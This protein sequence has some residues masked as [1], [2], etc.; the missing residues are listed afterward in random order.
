MAEE[1]RPGVLE[2]L[3][4]R[5]LEKA[6]APFDPTLID[7]TGLSDV[8]A[9]DRVALHLARQIRRSMNAL[10]EKARAGAAAAVVRAVLASLRETSRD[11]DLDDEELVE[12]ARLLRAIRTWLPDGTASAERSPLI[13]LLDTTLLTN[14]PGEP[15][16]G[17]QIDVEIESAN[18]IDLVMAFIR[19]SGINPIKDALRRH[20]ERGGRLRIITT[21]Y[22]GS[23]Q[24]SALDV[25]AA[26]GAE[27]RISY[28]LSTT[29]LHAKAWIFNRQA[30]FST[31]YIGS[32]NLTHSAQVAG[33]EWNVRVSG[34]RNPD[35]LEKMQAV[36]SAY[37]E[38]QDFVP[39]D[40]E[41]FDRAAVRAGQ[42]GPAIVISPIGVGPRPFQARLLEQLEMERAKGRHRN[43]LV[44]AT[45][46]GKTVMAALDYEQLSRTLPRARLLFIAHRKEILDQSQA[47]FCQVLQDATFG[48]KWAGGQRP[49]AF[50]HVFASIQSL[51]RA[52]LEH[53]GP[54][55]F[56]VVIVDEFHHAEA[57]TY[58]RILRHLQPRELLGL[59]A[60]PERADG[61]DILHWFG[62]RIAA[63]LR[64]W[65]A[66]E[67]QYLA[68]FS[69]FGIS[70]GLSL[71][72][73][74]WRRGVGYDVQA[75]TN[76]YT[77][78][79][80]WAGRVLKEFSSRVDDLSRVRA[81]GF[82]VSVDHAR[83]MADYFTKHGVL[84]ASVSG[85]TSRDEREQALR[86][87]ANGKL[88]A[89]FSVDVFN[90]GVDVPN[91]DAILMLRPTESATL[92]LQ[93]L[94]RG[95]R[96]A[97]G[98]AQCIVLDFVGQHRREFRFDRRF[99]ALLG[100]TRADVIRQVEAG[101]PYL[102]AGCHMELDR[103]AMETVLRNLRNA[104]PRG[105]K[106]QVEQIQVMLSKHPDPS[107]A[108]FLTESSL[109]LPDIYGA[110]RCWSDLR[111]AAGLP[112]APAG[113]AET[114][115]RKALSRLLHVTDSER[116]DVWTFVATDDPASSLPLRTRRVVAGLLAQLLDQVGTDLI[117][118]DGSLEAGL[119]FLRQH[120]QVVEELQQL[121]PL[122]SDRADHLLHP[123]SGRADVPLAVHGRYTRQEIL[124]AFG[125]ASRSRTVEWR[126]GVKWLRDE[127]ADLFTITLDKSGGSFSATT[128]Y[129]DYAISPTLMHWESQSGTRAASPTGLRYQNHAERGSQVYLFCRLRPDDRA[130]W[131][132]GPATYVRHEGERPMAITWRLEMPLPG[133]LFA[134]FAVAVA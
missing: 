111:E 81:L 51:S 127:R 73:I 95:L 46:T 1:L 32:S 70:D 91:V 68:P 132:L 116:L 20:C 125:D 41:E 10:P 128:R 100:G 4:T 43:L 98:K 86:D 119:A 78:D 18:S 48:E 129:R 35:V 60:T 134:D 85:E 107:L 49:D 30:G 52:D 23:T 63:E 28:D 97:P 61:Q 103:L 89:L 37:W 99:Q 19:T 115:L 94:G 15:R 40:P 92:F 130:F 56:D 114:T 62:G 39:Y 59:T 96:K 47:T 44:A 77:A 11:H 24:R 50:E 118:K 21:T 14:A 126:E 113:P 34:V 74:P 69:Y 65:S 6:I 133:D 76:L 122:L 54:K 109:D 71:E 104:I 67:Q 64:L 106:A 88:R 66:I 55:H 117:E 31:A 108:A 3:I 25:L 5:E 17:N 36:F 84:A 105:I 79:H 58:D 7:A 120:P 13:S 33:L 93:Q 83:F 110:G 29:R 80:L 53:L 90:E 38:S 75:L 57:S 121:A 27:I 124:G 8:E 12:P 87:L 112:V 102:P 42:T 2:H 72:D 22:T 82:C 101:F 131:F 26:L 16:V 123:L 9:P 45:G